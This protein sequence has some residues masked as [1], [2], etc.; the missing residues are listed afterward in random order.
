MKRE[1]KPG[2]GKVGGV[3]WGGERG[4]VG[5]LSRIT[6]NVAV[7]FFRQPTAQAGSKAAEAGHACGAE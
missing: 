1:P 5:L 3:G 6:F 2:T 7:L 4:D